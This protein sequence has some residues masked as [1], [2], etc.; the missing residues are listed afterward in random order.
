VKK[1]SHE[2]HCFLV[3]ASLHDFEVSDMTR[4]QMEKISTEN[5][6]CKIVKGDIFDRLAFPF[7]GLREV[8][9]LIYRSEWHR[10]IH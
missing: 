3:F 2:D 9:A 8:F 5:I 4:K 7:S 1:L 6:T 10:I